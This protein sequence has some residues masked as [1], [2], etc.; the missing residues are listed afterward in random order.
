MIGVVVGSS[1]SLRRPF[2]KCMNTMIRREIGP[3]DPVAM[4]GGVA[5][6]EHVGVAVPPRVGSP[7][8]AVLW[9][10]LGSDG[11]AAKAGRM[12]RIE[13]CRGGHLQEQPRQE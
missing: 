10:Q 4:G 13:E 1:E 7:A 5:A 6:A 12:H 3:G 2:P 8:A 9:Q 11:S